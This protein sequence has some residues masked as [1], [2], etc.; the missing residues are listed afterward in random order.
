MSYIRFK[1]G[2]TSHSGQNEAIPC[3]YTKLFNAICM[4][5]TTGIFILYTLTSAFAEKIYVVERERERLAVI[6]NGV[7]SGE[8]GNLGNL[9]HATVK[10]NKNFMYVI[11]RDGYLS[12]IETVSDS[13]IKQVKVGKS[14][15]GFIFTGDMVAVANYDPHDVVI[16][17][18]SLSTL[19][20]IETN[21][22]N[23][24]IKSWKRFLIFAL[25]D[26][27]E[28]WVLDSEKN[29]EVHKMIKNAGGMPFDALMS[30]NKYIVGLFN[31]GSVGM[32]DVNTMNYSRRNL[33][34]GEGEA[35]FKIPHFGT[36]GVYKD[37]AFIPAVGERRLHIVDINSFKH[38]GYIDLTGLP[39]FV[40]VSPDGRYIAVNYSGDKEDFLTVVDAKSRKV[41][42]DIKA[43]KRIMHIRF[44]EDSRRLYLSSYFDNTVRVLD[45]NEWKVLDEIT[46]PTPSGIFILPD[47]S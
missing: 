16:L 34:R 39:V 25:M 41:L 35:I 44:S 1:S 7:F 32:L 40:A 42:N 43:G 20:K 47:E 17:D 14:G 28:I 46:V 36:W 31:K 33:R 26:K 2:K 9:N 27:D 6:E 38:S 30:E 45:T 12:Q 13:L 5:V 8:I 10:F 3:S 4:V 23:V 24:G 22:K 18:E 29:F 15:I 11:S 21:S 19:K 37:S